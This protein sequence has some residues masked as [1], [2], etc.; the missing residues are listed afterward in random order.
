MKMRLR[1]L[2][3]LLLLSFLLAAGCAFAD[4]VT[5]GDV[6][7]V[8][9]AQPEGAAALT[10]TLQGV[11]SDPRTMQERTLPALAGAV[12]GVYT[13]GAGGELVPYPDRLILPSP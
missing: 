13:R 4:V 2:I 5:Y 3:G 6:T 9:A 8:F 11:Y 7:Y 10:L 12:F 1:R